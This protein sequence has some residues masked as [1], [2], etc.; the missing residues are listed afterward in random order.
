[1]GTATEQWG[2]SAAAAA[3]GASS[4]SSLSGM[5]RI[6]FA[7]LRGISAPFPLTAKLTFEEI[8]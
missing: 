5:R 3:A 8:P 7:M 6:D 1:M 4:F 2:V